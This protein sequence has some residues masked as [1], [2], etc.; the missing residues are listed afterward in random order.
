[1][2]GNISS[3]L[4]GF[5]ENFLVFWSIF[6]IFSENASFFIDFQRRSFVTNNSFLRIMYSKLKK[7]CLYSTD[8]G[9]EN[10]RFMLRNANNKNYLLYG[11]QKS[12]KK[13]V[14]NLCDEIQIQGIT[15]SSKSSLQGQSTQVLHWKTNFWK[16]YLYSQIISWQI[17]I[18]PLLENEQKI[19]KYKNENLILFFWILFQ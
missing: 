9:N 2:V 15:R 14:Y 3:F 6:G 7:S 12:E 16:C 13:V 5:C 4:I 10:S 1:M 17:I 19:M 18:H 11:P 8:C